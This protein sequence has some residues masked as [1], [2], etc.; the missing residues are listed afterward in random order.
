MTRFAE[1]LRTLA[2]ADVE[3]ILAGGVAAAA[4][5]SARSTQDIDVVYSRSERN[6]QRLVGTLGACRPYLRGA[7]AG[8]MKTRLLTLSRWRHLASVTTCWICRH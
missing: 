8:V 4:H 7:V 3:F 1:L 5:G 2:S 6:L